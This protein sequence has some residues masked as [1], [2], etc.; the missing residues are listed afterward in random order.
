MSAAEPPLR[1]LHALLRK[2]TETFAHEL[3]R[4][5]PDAPDWCAT[6][7][8]IARAVASIHGISPLLA[9]RLP[10]R[11]PPGWTQFLSEQKSHTAQRH[12][13]ID[14]LTRRIDRAACEQ[15]IGLMALKGTALHARGVY[16]PGERP[17]ADVDLLVREE[18]WA[19][20]ARLLTTLG[21]REAY[22]T[23]KHRV[24]VPIAQRAPATLGE[25]AANDMKIELHTRISEVLPLR[26]VDLSHLVV[27]MRLAPGLQGYPS[28]AATLLHILF[29]ASGAMALRC[30]RALHLEDIRRLCAIMS[31]ADWEELLRAAASC[32]GGLWWAYPPL[33]LADR[34]Y[35]C[36]PN[37]VHTRVAGDCQRSLRRLCDRRILSD[38]SLSYTWIT[39]FPGI[40]WSRTVGEMVAY[41]AGRLWPGPE[42]R[43][44]REVMPREEPLLW[45]GAWSRMS[46]GRRVVHWLV[47]RQGRHETVRTVRTALSVDN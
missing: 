11:G 44:M 4:P 41:A 20:A 7:W 15:G 38:V 29:H 36:V 22:A 18:D 8:L 16:A 39:A 23:W 30:V 45:G 17:M 46:Q 12:L 26:P 5:S 2:T 32:D 34:Y 9:D 31:I 19:R 6:E 27:P 37:P 35:S 47:S 10:W 40:E 14:E 24:F 1:R 28:T 25:H 21:F 33:A 42:A 13:V 3:A 43:R